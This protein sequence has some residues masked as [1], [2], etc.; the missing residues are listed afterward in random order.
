D[1]PALFL[2]TL[3]VYYQ[4][5]I[6]S[7]VSRWSWALLSLFAAYGVATTHDAFAASRALLAA[8]QTLEH[9][10]VPRTAITAGFNYDG[11]MQVEITG[12]V[13]NQFVDHPAG[14][15]RRVQCAGTEAVRLWYL[16]VMPSIRARYFVELT[17]SA[18]LEDGPIAP[19]AYTSWLPPARRRVF[20]QRLPEGAYVGCQ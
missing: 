3:C 4:A 17:R 7:K 9:A 16:D 15:Y 18:G 20:T 13:N 5:R 1:V 14:A 2:L 12:H 19:V 6:G 8:A 10:G 11:W